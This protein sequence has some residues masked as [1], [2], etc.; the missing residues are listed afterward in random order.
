MDDRAHDT[1]SRRTGP[2]REQ[3]EA[4]ATITGSLHARQGS[5]CGD[6]AAEAIAVAKEHGLP[7]WCDDTALRQKARE[8]YRGIQHARPRHH[9]QPPTGRI[10]HVSGGL[11]T[12]RYQ[13]LVGLVG[14][15]D[16][17]YTPPAGLLDELAEPRSAPGPPG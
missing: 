16:A 1:H 11:R 6:A 10:E 8:R 3:D 7:L 12:Q 5:R 17:G 14:S 9:P 4:L 2:V 15:H 13:Q